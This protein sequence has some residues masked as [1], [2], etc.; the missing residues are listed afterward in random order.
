MVYSLK[1]NASLKGVLFSSFAMAFAGLGDALLYPVLPVY[2]EEL[3]ISALW[4]GIL[5]SVNRFVRIPG[6]T[7]VSWLVSKR[8]YKQTIL[9]ASI[10]AVIST[11]AY[12]L[13]L[14][15]TFF[16]VARLVWGLSYSSLRV[17]SLGYAA[18]ANRR[19]NLMFGLNAG[20]KTLG[21]VVALYLGPILMQRTDFSLSFLAMGGL[22]FLAI[23]FA[24]KLPEIPFDKTRASFRKT[25]KFTPINVI[26]FLTSF[27][28]DGVL[29]VVISKL[30]V[31]ESSEKL[32][33]IVGAYLLFR[34]VCSTF[35]S[36]V[37]G[38]LSDKVGVQRVFRTSLVFVLISLLLIVFGITEIG[39][40]SCFLFNSFIVAMLPAV[41]IRNDR[42][43][44]LETLTSITTWWDIGAASGTLLALFLITLL[45]AT[46]LFSILFALL[47]LPVLLLYRKTASL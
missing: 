4:I 43:T 12:G 42:D 22:S 9:I 40:L 14:G 6:N 34:R 46:T 24:Y 13:Q 35:M 33:L 36:V 31:A 30:L 37:S 38:W 1:K 20:I 10:G 21:A 32:I 44:R 23:I 41:A 18:Q 28:I 39:I 5:L 17:G 3:G 47:L 27:G 19:E 26:T 2:G 29:V 8:G 25:L 45:G 11:I 15:I 16:L 7:L